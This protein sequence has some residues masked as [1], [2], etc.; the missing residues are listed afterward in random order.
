MAGGGGVDEG[1]GEY[2]ITSDG[3]K[4]SIHSITEHLLSHFKF[5]IMTQLFLN[6]LFT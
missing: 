1:H 5:I 4:L 3:S 6:I 2:K